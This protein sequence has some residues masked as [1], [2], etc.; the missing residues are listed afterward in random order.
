MQK[1][2]WIQHSIVVSFLLA[3]FF[4]VMIFLLGLSKNTVTDNSIENLAALK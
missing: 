4:F 2:E 1:A 3:S